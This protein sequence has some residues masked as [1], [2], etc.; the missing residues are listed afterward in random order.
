MV[1]GNSHRM[2]S[3]FNGRGDLLSTQDALG[4]FTSWTQDAFGNTV[5]RVDARN[6][7]TTYAL[8][9]L[10]RTSGQVYIDW[11]RVTNTWDGAGQQLTQQ[12]LLGIRSFGYDLDGRQTSVAFPTGLN[13]THTFDLRHEVAQVIVTRR[14]AA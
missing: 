7:P 5:L 2:T 4:A 8:D 12:D 9:A 6:W 1:E 13:L 11:T 3:S 10:N 14:R